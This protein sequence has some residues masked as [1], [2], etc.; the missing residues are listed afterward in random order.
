MAALNIINNIYIDNES[1]L[2]IKA[3]PLLVAGF[4]VYVPVHRENMLCR[5]Q[6]SFCGPQLDLTQQ[7]QPL[8]VYG[9]WNSIGTVIIRVYGVMRSGRST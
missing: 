4:S 3:R 8:Q 1:Y 9:V 2:I 5:V 7:A 6:R